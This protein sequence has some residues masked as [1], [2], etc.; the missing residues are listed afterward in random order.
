MAV[1]LDAGP[2]NYKSGAIRVVK[3]TDLNQDGATPVSASC[4]CPT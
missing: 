1:Y 2:S 4:L 3:S